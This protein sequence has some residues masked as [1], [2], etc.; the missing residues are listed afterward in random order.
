[1]NGTAN[2]T[3]D[4]LALSDHMKSTAFPTSDHT[5]FGNGPK[6]EVN[7]FYIKN[8]ILVIKLMWHNPIPKYKYT[9]IRG[10]LREVKK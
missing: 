9:Y 6:T 5:Y 1:M 4:S 10:V 8:L 2:A 7:I 3:Y